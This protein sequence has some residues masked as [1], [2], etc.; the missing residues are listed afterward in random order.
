MTKRVDVY[1]KLARAAK[2]GKGVKL[3][4][5][6]VFALIRFDDAIISAAETYSKSCVCDITRFGATCEYCQNC[7]DS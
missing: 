3:T 4:A 5:K 1:V 7:E 2:A 6:D